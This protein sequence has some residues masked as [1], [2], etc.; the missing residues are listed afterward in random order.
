MFDGLRHYLGM[1]KALR[2]QATRRRD[3]D[4]DI[5]SARSKK[6][7]NEVENLQNYQHMELRFVEDEIDMD[8]SDY[9]IGLAQKY[10]VPLPQGEEFW[11]HSEAF[12][13]GYLSRKGAAQVR[14][15]IRAE[16][17]AMWDYWQARVTLVL[18]VFGSVIGVLAY[19]KK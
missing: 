5:K 14:S 16:R 1:R 13:R 8:N 9:L 4:R 3:F 7:H 19:F 18:S 6:D 15:D 12:G 2:H 10:L 17:K 11:T